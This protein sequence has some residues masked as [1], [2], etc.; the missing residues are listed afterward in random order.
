VADSKGAIHSIQPE[1]IE[2]EASGLVGLQIHV[3]CDRG[4][5]AQSNASVE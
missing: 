5:A 1:W 4:K 2:A 3:L